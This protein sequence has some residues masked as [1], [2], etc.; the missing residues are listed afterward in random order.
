VDISHDPFLYTYPGIVTA[1]LP[2]WEEEGEV[3]R[4]LKGIFPDHIASHTREQNSYFGEDGLFKIMGE[5][6]GSI[7]HTT[8]V[9]GAV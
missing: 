1:E 9:K 7:T 3:W 5:P 6:E 8:I 4:P 2:A